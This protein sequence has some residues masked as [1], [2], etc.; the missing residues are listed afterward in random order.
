MRE[1]NLHITPKVETLPA[2]S[3]YKRAMLRCFCNQT[4]Q[5]RSLQMCANST[6]YV[7][8]GG[9]EE[10]K[11]MGVNLMDFEARALDYYGRFTTQDPLA[12]KYPSWS[13]YAYCGGNPINA[14]DPDGK[15]WVLSYVN[16]AAEYYY[17]RTVTSQED[18][19][20]KYG[21][22]SGVI[23]VATGTVMTVWSKGGDKIQYI[24]V[25]DTKENKYGI[26][27]D[28]NGNTLDNSKIIY[29]NSYTIFGTTDNSV[30]AETLHKNMFGSS[31]IGP[32]NPKDY[33]KN[34]SYQYKPVWSPT[35]MA[36]FTHDLDYNAVG[37]K[38][39]GGAL[40]PSTKDADMKL[41]YNCEQVLKNPNSTPE[42]K[43]RAR[44]I[45]TGFSIINFFKPSAP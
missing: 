7:K 20:N 29:G 26:V 13:P 42:E 30:N 6:K 1:I 4:L 37:A 22:K 32:N 19:N 31:Y 14:I 45:I 5:A 25:N 10:E 12:E 21:E 38:G 23:H 39:V 18:V 11:M 41:I 28:G 44:K 40:S 15:D 43:S 35:E 2:T 34:D 17:D 16:G 24:F 8:F 33:N 3:P 27:L 9:K 36:A